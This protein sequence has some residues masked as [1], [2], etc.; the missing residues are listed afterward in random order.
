MTRHEK[1]E[2]ANWITHGIAALCSIVGAVFLFVTLGTGS[3]ASR[4]ISV[5][6]YIATV[7]ALYCASTLYHIT[8]SEKWKHRFRIADHGA[9]YLKIAGTYTPFL[10]LALREHY[11]IVLLVVLWTLATVGIIFKTFFVKRFNLIST[12]LYL[13][14]GWL[15]L[16]LIRPLYHAVS[17][18][19]FLYLMA[20]GACFTIGVIFYLWEKMPYNHAVWHLFVI[21]G[22]AFHFASVYL[23][24]TQ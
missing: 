20:G 14:M 16:F 3:S 12:I 23:F 22:S 2:L 24:I 4:W 9:I 17:T 15:A 6:I 19:V 5:G 7:V 18:D 1:E 13:F 11:G 10:I 8:I 21:G